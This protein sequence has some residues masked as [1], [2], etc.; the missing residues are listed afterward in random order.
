MKIVEFAY[1]IKYVLIVY[2]KKHIVVLY[3][4]SL[5]RKTVLIL[6]GYC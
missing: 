4:L 3:F 2:V 6:K 1:E 5:G